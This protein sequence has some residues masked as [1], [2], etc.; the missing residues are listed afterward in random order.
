[1]YSFT[2]LDLS[3]QSESPVFK[4]S[5]EKD[6]IEEIS[7][8]DTIGRMQR[9]YSTKSFQ[10]TDGF[11]ALTENDILMAAC[12]LCRY[13][14]LEFCKLYAFIQ[15]P[16][17]KSILLEALNKVKE[18]Y[19]IFKSEPGFFEVPEENT[20][21]LNSYYFTAGFPCAITD[22]ITFK[23]GESGNIVS[24][25]GKSISPNSGKLVT[26]FEFGQTGQSEAVRTGY[27]TPERCTKFGKIL[28]QCSFDEYTSLVQALN[29]TSLHLRPVL[30]GYRS[31]VSD[32]QKVENTIKSR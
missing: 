29:L 19:K 11:G 20:L 31:F 4:V 12:I 24:I 15:S 14:P 10:T 22:S 21:M 9:K 5:K 13:N 27:I 17:I 32:I 8:V 6:R 26:D 1:M 18:E 7:Y 23:V 25:V 28:C 30:D 3:F 2:N 16:N